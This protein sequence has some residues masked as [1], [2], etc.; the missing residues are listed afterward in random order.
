M[1][2]QSTLLSLAILLSLTLSFSLNAQEPKNHPCEKIKTAC[3]SAGFIKGDHKDKKGL[4]I[5]CMK[6]VLEGQSVTGVTITSEDV[7]AC[8]EKRAKHKEKKEAKK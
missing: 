1:K 2:K 8:K 6:P 3:E 5:D 4:Y 7:S